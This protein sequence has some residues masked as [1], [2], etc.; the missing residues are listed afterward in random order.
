MNPLEKVI[1]GIGVVG[2]L[3]GVPE[4]TV[5]SKGVANGLSTEYNDGYDFGPDSYNPSITSGVPLTQT[6]GI[7][8]AGDFVNSNGGGEVKLSPGLFLINTTIIGSNW[9]GVSIIGSGS[10]INSSVVNEFGATTISPSDTFSTTAIAL[11]VPTA[12]SSINYLPLISVIGTGAA[13]SPSGTNLQFKNFL[14]SGKNSLSG[15]VLK[16]TLGMYMNGIWNLVVEHV[17]TQLLY[18]GKYFNLNGPS[19]GSNW[20]INSTDEGPYDIGTYWVSDEGAMN[21]CCVQGNSPGGNFSKVVSFF[22]GGVNQ[23][24]PSHANNISYGSSSLILGDYAI[25]S[26]VIRENSYANGPAIYISSFAKLMGGVICNTGAN[27]QPFITGNGN[28]VQSSISDVI[29]IPTNSSGYTSQ[30]FNYNFGSSATT[31][32]GNEV[33]IKDCILYNASGFNWANPV[34]TATANS[35]YVSPL[36]LINITNLRSLLSVAFPTNP[37][38]SATVYQNTNPYDIRIYLPVYATTAGTAGTV[39]YGEDASSTVTEM[40]ARY[41]NGATSSTAVD[42][43]ELVVPAGH[44]YEFTASGVT[45]GTATVKAV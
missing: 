16:N 12:P 38:D 17:D 42:I 35:G 15:S 2:A 5:S 36:K 14:I 28:L 34:I 13:T 23:T 3:T 31:I 1:I 21:N 19:G 7:Q 22:I 25:V 43:V 8:E 11:Q 33:I 44:Y 6:S 32:D 26:N 4:I 10:L 41:V 40:T 30:L 18:F 27:N 37:P 29:F 24:V 39:A 20:Y 45:F 9:N